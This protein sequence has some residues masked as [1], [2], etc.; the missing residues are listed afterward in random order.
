MFMKN[1]LLK[2]SFISCLLVIF[3]HHN[4]TASVNMQSDYTRE[5]EASVSIPV[6]DSHNS[7]HKLI[8]KKSDFDSIN[9]P[10]Y[11][12]FYVKAGYYSSYNGENEGVIIT[13]SGTAKESRT[14]SYYDPS[15]KNQKHPIKRNR[16]NS[17][18]LKRI[19][20]QGGDYWIIQGLSIYRVGSLRGI[21]FSPNSNSDHNIIDQVLVYGG[22]A[23]SVKIWNSNDYNTIQ[24]SVIRDTVPTPD[25][26]SVGIALTTNG[27]SLFGPYNTHI[28]GNEI[29]DT[30]DAIHIIEKASNGQPTIAEGTIIEDN[31]LFIT[32]DLYSDCNG[33]I[34]RTGPCACAENAIDIKSATT[35]EPPSYG[36][37]IKVLNNRMWGFRNTDQKCGGSG[38][39]GSAVSLH[40]PNADYIFFENNYIWDSTGGIVVNAAGSD[41]VSIINNV[42][43]HINDTS[44]GINPT[45]LHISKA[46]DYVIKN[47]II[48]E[49]TYFLN[50]GWNGSTGADNIFKCNT[51]IRGGQYF[52]NYGAVTTADYNFYYATTSPYQN[53]TNHD[54]VYASAA[55]SQNVEKCFTTHII[56]NPTEFCIPFAQS[57]VNSPQSSSCK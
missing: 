10:Q 35:K 43:Y 7:T 36:A 23:A 4:A 12:H 24:N 33:N 49:S 31:D 5:Y 50:A 6:Y 29:Y 28:V 14:L 40:H 51:I 56:S 55:E 18:N 54:Q 9:D 30:T 38:S 21:E 8:T 2:I 46:N 52:G 47:N 3:F 48:I 20:F 27:S 57:T 22:T 39:D 11:K 37:K 15:E 25:S 44:S 53:T 32:A 1:I 42:I 45:A 17:A 34:N 26:D 13:A 41:H 19:E 16:K